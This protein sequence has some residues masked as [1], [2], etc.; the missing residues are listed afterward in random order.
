MAPRW[1]RDY[2]TADGLSEKEDVNANLTLFTLA[3]PVHFEEAVKH[4]K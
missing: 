1:M 2:V 3:D 4:D